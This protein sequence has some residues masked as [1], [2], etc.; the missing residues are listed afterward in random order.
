MSITKTR[1]IGKIAKNGGIKKKE[2]KK[3]VELFLSI[4][5]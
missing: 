1:F 4:E 5:R 2:A 3:E